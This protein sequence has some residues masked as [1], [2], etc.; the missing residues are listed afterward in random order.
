MKLYLGFRVGP[1]D[2]C[3][4]KERGLRQEEEVSTQGWPQILERG[5]CELENVIDGARR[6][7][8]K[9]FFP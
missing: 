7:V 5:C 2:C 1:H 8:Q 4:G 6:G 3:L 9:T